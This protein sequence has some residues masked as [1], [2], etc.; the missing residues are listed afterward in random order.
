M[1]LNKKIDY[2]IS[3]PDKT[4]YLMKKLIKSKLREHYIKIFSS[5]LSDKDFFKRINVTNQENLINRSLPPFFMDSTHK[6]FFIGY[7]K[8][9]YPE[10]ISNTKLDAEE[11]IDH[12]FSFLGSDKIKL[13]KKIN[14]HA[15]FKNK[16]YWNKNK[17]YIGNLY[18][19][20]YLKDEICADVKIPWELSR[21]HHLITLG[22]AYWYTNDEKYT[23]EFMNQID[24][25][26]KNNK[27]ELGVNW[28][29]TMDVA[30]RAINWIWGF[31]F[32]ESSEYLD[33]KFKILFYK[34]L[35]LHGLIIFNNLELENRNNH[36]LSNYLGLIYVGIFFKET[37]DGK[38]W[39][40][41][42]IDGIKKEIKIQVNPD[43]VDYEY[44]I[45]YHKLVTE[46]FISAILLCINNNI[47][48]PKWFM[49]HLEKMIEFIMY[50]IK[51]DGSAP[52][53]GDC[54]DGRIHIL[55]NYGNW[56]KLDHR[57]L[58]SIGA[59]L[60]NRKD[61]LDQSNSISEETFWLLGEKLN[62]KNFVE[63]YHTL[64]SKSFLYSGIYIMREKTFYMII[65]GSSP[66]PKTPQGHRHNS[67]LSFE[68]FAYDKSFILDTGSYVYTAN[69]EM[70]NLFRSTKY[71]NTIEIDKN[72]QNSYIKDEIFDMG[73]D[74]KV[75]IGK[76]ET[77]SK[78]DYLDME[79]Y[80][81][82]RLKNPIIHRRQI[83][84]D[85]KRKLWIIKDSL[86]GDGKHKFDLYFHLAPMKLEIHDNHMICSNFKVGAN[87]AIIPLECSKLFSEVSEGWISYNYGKKVKAPILKYSKN[88][89]APT[90]FVTLIFPFEDKKELENMLNNLDDIKKELSFIN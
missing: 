71:H 59:Y 78:Y 34:N 83:Y 15:D 43:G 41:K 36:L 82:K 65:D 22:K 61:F 27:P 80:G 28:A 45:C 25:W 33:P 39:L 17:Y 31:Y 12:K 4:K 26:I 14:W 48:F 81:Y 24:S 73:T 11:I 89:N 87:I 69:K 55:S 23:N 6:S 60:F 84:F 64:S 51:P 53:I 88:M 47:K 9:N 74:A 63:N 79:H 72:D 5:E 62:Y 85:K 52:Q 1:S 2:I 7:I 3:N 42:G 90:T 77:N 50:Y 86:N 46:I 54:D 35:Y 75:N 70:R 66:I 57:Y 21:F 32:F 76:W 29:C 49:D 68:L 40:M 13:D 19:L 8:N 56:N 20:N 18:Y 44:S 67:A 16:Y 37:K 58:L 38:K 10:S 30:I